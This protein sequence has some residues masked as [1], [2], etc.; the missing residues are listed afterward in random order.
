MQWWLSIPESVRLF[1]AFVLMFI[2]AL[3][4]QFALNQYV[5]HI[6]LL[7]GI[8]SIAAVSL[9]LTNGYTGLFSLGHAGFM[10]IG[11]YVS[12]LLTFPVRLRIAYDLPLLPSFLGGPAYQWPFLPSLL[13]G[14]L[15]ASIAALLVGAPVLRLRGHYLSVASLGLM[16]IITTLAK[17]LKNLTRGAAGIQ[18]IPRYTS[19]WW[20]YVWLVITIYITWRLL[21]SSYGR[22]ML[23]I[24]ESEI[25]AQ[26]QGIY[27]AR[28]KLLS[29]IIGAFFAGIAGGL[30]AHFARSIRPY[31]FSFTM[32]FQIVIMLII[33][34]AGS[35]FGPVLGAAIIIALKYALKP[36][37]ERL[38]VY[39]L[40][41]IVYAL[42]LILVMLWFPKGVAGGL[43]QLQIKFLQLTG[44]DGHDGVSNGTSYRTQI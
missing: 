20:V 37:E 41:E 43:K 5:L 12:T 34:G 3:V 19:I 22:A 21:R 30:Y 2:V 31:E 36:L 18:A 7:M 16:V 33:G 35:L 11:A 44:G 25:A 42:L 27:P 24:R 13:A 26:A 23:A 9:N 6:V 15:I 14:G 4:S 8:Y 28:F 40:V 17:G 29:F 39:G 32:T 10:A 38:G 1:I